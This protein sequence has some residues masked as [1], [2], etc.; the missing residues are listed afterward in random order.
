MEDVKIK[1]V[2]REGYAKIA[3][4]ERSCCATVGFCCGNT[5]LA[6]DISKK[7]GV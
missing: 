1:E 6:E 7:I 2:V 4:K 3:K 5:G